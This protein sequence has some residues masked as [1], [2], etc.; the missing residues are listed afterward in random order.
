VIERFVQRGGGVENAA[1]QVAHELARAGDDVTVVTR[2]PKRRD[3]R[4]AQ[5]ASEAA[6]RSGLGIEALRVPNRW[7]PLRVVA[8]SRAAGRAVARG[9]YDVVH[10]FSRTRHQD[11]YRA[12]GGSHADYLRLTHARAPATLRRL[13]PRHRVLLSLEDRVF[14]DP[15]QRIQCASSLVAD[16][17][18]GRHGVSPERILLLPNGVDV[19]RFGAPACREAG[20]RLRRELDPK[21]ARIWLFPASGWRRKGLSTLLEAIAR[22]G[23]PDLHLWI[24]GRDDPRPWRRSLAASGLADRVRFLGSRDDL[25]IVYG[26]ADG[27]VLPTRYDAFANVTLEAAAAGLPIITTRS[28]GA[29]E[30]LE[31]DLCV[32]DDPEDA[33]ALAAA[34]ARFVD[35][36][37]GRELGRRARMRARELDWAGHVARLREEYRRIVAARAS[38][39]RQ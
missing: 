29:A 22:S 19:E 26:A 8:F 4:A 32:I 33:A 38:S 17:L 15:T 18:T 21:A 1:W 9:G 30:W 12:G 39:G 25:E 35:P 37:A 20:R 27:M 28:N 13:S 16:A 24:A 11:L 3:A 10:G 34:F 36:D 2:H 5:A 6:T 31:G 14:R 7:Q 23:D